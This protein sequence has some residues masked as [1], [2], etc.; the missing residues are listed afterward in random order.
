MAATMGRFHDDAGY[1]VLRIE[2]DLWSETFGDELARDDAAGQRVRGAAGRHRPPERGPDRGA[3][4]GTALPHPDVVVMP[5][6]VPARSKT[7]A[8][9]GLPPCR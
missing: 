1:G 2:T 8:A 9:D 3:S 6:F 4:P 7:S 5:I